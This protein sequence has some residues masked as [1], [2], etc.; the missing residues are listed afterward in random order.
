M[1]FPWVPRGPARGCAMLVRNVRK[2]LRRRPRRKLKHL[3]PVVRPARPLTEG[4]SPKLGKY[5]W[6]LREV[7]PPP[8]GGFFRGEHLLFDWWPAV[9]RAPKRAN[10][11]WSKADC[12]RGLRRTRILLT[13]PPSGGIP[14]RH[15]RGRGGRSPCKATLVFLAG[16]RRKFFFEGA[17]RVQLVFNNLSQ[18]EKT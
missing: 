8:P 15:R 11:H 18:Q 6:A 9:E 12:C 16:R 1:F 13:Q 10:R 3:V 17:R 4:K 7:T 14:G 2:A 5:R